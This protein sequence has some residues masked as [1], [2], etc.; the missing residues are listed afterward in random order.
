MIAW[1]CG[2][3]IQSV[4]IGVLIREGVLPK[5][6]LSGIADTGREV[7][8][9]W[10]Y[11]DGVLNP[12]LAAAGVTVERIP[13][14]LASADLYS[15]KGELLIPAYD[16]AEGRLSTFCSGWWKRD[17]FERWLRSRDV[18]ECDCWI[19]YSLDELYRVKNDH[20]HWCRY[21]HPLIDLRLTR[22]ACV[23]LIE[24]AG[25]PIPHKS[26]CWG[27]PHQNAE[28][29]AEVKANPDE[30][31]KAVELDRQIRE[32]DERG[33]L[34]L[35]SSRRPLELADLSVDESMPLFRRCQ[36][37]GCWT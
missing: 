8:S 25:L 31:A 17:V 1:S 32:A 2:G 10:D 18:A 5:P 35:H 30:W 15:K 14:S 3:G 22:G 4:A 6:N 29:W 7:Q 26:R 12:Y 27:C 36:D 20:R 34:F 21:R 24:K 16:A 28:E 37:G 23:S 33:G 11:L 9:T 19:G 13:H